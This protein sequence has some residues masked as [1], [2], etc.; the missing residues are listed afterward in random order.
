MKTEKDLNPGWTRMDPDES[1]PR[2]SPSRRG[3]IAGRARRGGAAADWGDSGFCPAT[4]DV[5]VRGAAAVYGETREMEAWAEEQACETCAVA[6]NEATDTLAFV[7]AARDCGYVV[8]RGT[9]DLRNWLSD[10]DCRRVAA[11]MVK[12]EGRR[13]KAETDGRK[14]HEGFAVALASIEEE[15]EEILA[16]WGAAGKTVFF[17]GHSLGGALA[18][19]AAA[20]REDQRVSGGSPVLPWVYTFGQ[21]RVGN[22]AWAKWY[23]GLMRERSF[24]VVHADDVVARVPWLMGSFRHAGHEVFFPR[25]DRTDRSDG[26]DRTDRTNGMGE[27]A[28]LDP[29]WVGKLPFDLCG[30][31]RR[32]TLDLEA[33]LA[34][35]HVDSYVALLQWQTAIQCGRPDPSG[36]LNQGREGPATFCNPQ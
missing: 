27:A 28:L 10:L 23:D 15:L 5:L 16:G 31:W 30:L 13:Q 9:R 21:P 19:L 18:M 14:V 3:G 7:A 6:G 29:S 32:H 22:R 17:A 20:R 24:R 25:M 35:H 11:D 8:F 4:A 34:D 26:T 33:L 36:P 1:S 2:P 12:A